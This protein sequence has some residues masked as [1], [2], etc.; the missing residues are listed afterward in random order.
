MGPVERPVRPHW[1]KFGD[2]A[3]LYLRTGLANAQDIG[4]IGKNAGRSGMRPTLT[5]E[6]L[7]CNEGRTE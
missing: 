2:P 3:A 7:W 4:A 1:W 5:D 6:V